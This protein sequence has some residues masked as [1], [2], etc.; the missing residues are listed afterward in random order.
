ML[1]AGVAHDHDPY[2][3]IVT[4]RNECALKSTSILRDNVRVWAYSRRALWNFSWLAEDAS[5]RCELSNLLKFDGLR[6]S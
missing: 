3:S 2:L 6:C 5:M 4:A 1:V